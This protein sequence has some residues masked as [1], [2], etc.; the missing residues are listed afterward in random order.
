MSLARTHREMARLMAL[1]LLLG[2][3]K[4]ENESRN[5]QNPK[6]KK[7]FPPWVCGRVELWYA[8]IK[9]CD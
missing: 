8:V 6:A 7:M 9:T 4:P 5:I 2:K 3:L 1:T